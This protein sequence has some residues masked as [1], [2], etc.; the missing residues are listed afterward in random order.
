MLLFPMPDPNPQQV[1]AFEN[2]LFDRYIH[3]MLRI[4][5]QLA[6]T[7]LPILLPVNLVGGKNIPGGVRGLDQLSFAN[8]GFSHTNWYWVHLLVAACVTAFVCLILQFELQ[9]YARF[10]V[11]FAA[12]QTEGTVI[13]VSSIS[14]RRLTSEWIQHHFGDVLGGIRGIK[15]NRDYR[16]ACTKMRRWAKLFATLEAS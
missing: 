6:S 3:T 12:A 9:S 14:S 4:F 13:L 11:V 2:Y 10:Q 1:L 5:L 8:V 15:I 16:R 7:A